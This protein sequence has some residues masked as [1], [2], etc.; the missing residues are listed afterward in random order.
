MNGWMGDAGDLSQAD[1]DY[2]AWKDNL[3]R[4]AKGDPDW[5][6]Y[7]P[8]DPR[9]HVAWWRRLLKIPLP[10]AE[11]ERAMAKGRVLRGTPKWDPVTGET[12]RY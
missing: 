6:F 12:S 4:A 10:E 8:G 9:P 2:L 5:G 3:R 11:V 7:Y 1:L